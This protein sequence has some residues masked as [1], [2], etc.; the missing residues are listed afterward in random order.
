MVHVEFEGKAI[1]SPGFNQQPRMMFWEPGTCI[2]AEVGGMTHGTNLDT[3][4]AYERLL[5]KCLP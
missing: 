1:D 2:N 5:F 4:F 3:C